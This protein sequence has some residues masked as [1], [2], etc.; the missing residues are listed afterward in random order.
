MNAASSNIVSKKWSNSDI[1]YRINTVQV[2][3][4]QSLLNQIQELRLNIILQD[5]DSIKKE[6]D[7]QKTNILERYRTVILIVIN[8]L[9]VYLTKK[10]LGLSFWTDNITINFWKLCCFYSLLFMYSEHPNIHRNINAL[11]RVT[12]LKT[13]FGKESSVRELRAI[14]RLLPFMTVF[15][16]FNKWN[17]AGNI[18]IDVII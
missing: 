8:L 12:I 4:C 7:C 2:F 6:V 17:N 3:A 18:K 16:I 15:L 14:F 5:F 9:C 1:L 11:Y 10:Y 13:S